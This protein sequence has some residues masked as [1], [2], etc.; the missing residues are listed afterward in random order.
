ML[1]IY[2]F[3]VVYFRDNTIEYDIQFFDMKLFFLI[4]ALNSSV[5]SKVTDDFHG[6]TYLVETLDLIIK[7]NKD[8]KEYPDKQI[9]LLC[10]ILKVLFNLTVRSPTSPLT[11][12]E[13]ATQLRR[14]A[15]VIHD[16]ILCK[17]G[18]KEKQKELCS[19][20]VNLLT[21]IPSSCFTELISPLSKSNGDLKPFEGC[22]MSV[23][24]IL[25]DFLKDR[26]ESIQKSTS[27]HELLSPIL[28]VLVCTVRCNCVLRRYI[29]SV[30]LPPLTDVK[31]RPEEGTEL[32]NHLC[33][34][35]TTPATQVRDLVAELLFVICKENGEFFIFVI[36]FW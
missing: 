34:L 35:L 5:R 19:N 10:E 31:K 26:L 25:V 33:R 12:D 36:F 4:T 21:N 27:Y 2:F 24:N 16:L 18:S 13:E 3:V 1:L 32:R 30:I 15:A 11:E 28:T 6:L 22:D 14:L 8:A 9:D 7:N 17:A 20:I 29:R 23:I